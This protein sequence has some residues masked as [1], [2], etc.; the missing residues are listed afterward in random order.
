M[1]SYRYDPV[2]HVMQKTVALEDQQ[3][4]NGK[5]AG[6]VH[7]TVAVNDTQKERVLAIDRGPLLPMPKDYHPLDHAHWYERPLVRWRIWW[8]GFGQPHQADYYVCSGCGK[9][10]SHS[11]IK[12]GGCG[13]QR[14]NK[15]QPVRMTAWVKFKILAFPFL[16]RH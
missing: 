6:A 9:L 16:V 11:R 14:S 13:C 12:K 5:A 3:A 2:F 10:V 1:D 8:H 7:R 15:L 4:V